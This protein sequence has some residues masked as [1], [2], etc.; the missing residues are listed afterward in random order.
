MNYTRFFVGVTLMAIMTYLPRVLPLVVF[1]KKI[2][3]PFI[4]SF[5]AYVP[6]AVLAAMTFPD[7]FSSTNSLLS[8]LVG[9]AAAVVLIFLNGNLVTVAL[10]ATGAVFVAEQLMR[11]WVG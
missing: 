11:L 10:G 6:Y 5:L 4:K 9:M 3:N 8:A 2:E 7:I 1:R